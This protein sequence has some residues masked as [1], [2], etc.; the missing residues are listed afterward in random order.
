V[1]DK[2]QASEN[3]EAIDQPSFLVKVSGKG[4]PLILIP[5][6]MSNGSIYD[7]LA[8][9]LA[10]HYQVHVISVKGFAGIP[11]NGEFSLQQLAED[12]VAYIESANLQKPSIIGH[13]LGGL[14]AFKLACEHENLI[15]KVISID[16]L[17]FIGPIFTHNNATTVA[18]LNPQAQS[19]RMM[20]SSMNGAQLALQAQQGIYIQA[21]SPKDQAR[22]IEMTRTSNPSTAGKAMFDVMQT[23]LRKPLTKT[24]TPI[25]MLGGSGAFMQISQLPHQQ[26]DLLYKS[27]FKKVKNATVIMN[28]TARHYMMFDAPEWLLQQIETFLEG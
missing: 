2:T 14:M 15:G 21:K 8:A 19:M 9:Q 6:L 28:A 3:A 13:S 20:F 4:S 10:S 22:I 12:I 5:G 11:P 27:Q 16:G 17:P 23:D 1:P 18:M 24:N 25:L 7:E 26:V